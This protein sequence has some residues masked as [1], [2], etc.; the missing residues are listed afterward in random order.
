[1]LGLSTLQLNRPHDYSEVQM[2]QLELLERI[3]VLQVNWQAEQHDALRDDIRETIK[4]ENDVA[5]ALDK[6]IG[7]RNQREAPIATLPFK[8]PSEYQKLVDPYDK[9][10]PVAARARS[11]L[12]A[13][14]SPCHV[15][16]GGGNAQMELEFTTVI[17]K[18]RVIDATPV[19]HKFDLPAARTVA[20]GA[21][22]RSVLLHRMSHRG[23]EKMPQ[24][25]TS[26][27]DDAA[28]ERLRQ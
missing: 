10:Q 6:I 4:V 16:A 22:E 20:P 13:N 14:C 8:R 9:T 17:D 18:M 24:L 2:N 5:A 1:V 19:H 28:V 25:A 27:V 3:G 26:V 7:T 21:P 11:Y 23:A 12:H 15:E